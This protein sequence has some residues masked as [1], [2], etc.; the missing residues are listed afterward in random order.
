[1]ADNSIVVGSGQVLRQQRCCPASRLVLAGDQREFTV[2]SSYVLANGLLALAVPNPCENGP[3][4]L[5]KP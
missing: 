4:S 2:I 5:V 3:G 1:M